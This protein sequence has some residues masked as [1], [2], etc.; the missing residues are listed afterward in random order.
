MFPSEPER[1]DSTYFLDLFASGSQGILSHNLS[2]SPF[3]S[4]QDLADTAINQIWWSLLDKVRTYFQEFY[5]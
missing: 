3:D 4:A 2:A 5:Q 1:K